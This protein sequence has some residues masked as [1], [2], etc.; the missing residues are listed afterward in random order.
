MEKNDCICID[1]QNCIIRDF[2]EFPMTNTE[3]NLEK[4]GEE[5]IGIF[6]AGCYSEHNKNNPDYETSY[7]DYFL[8]TEELFFN[9]IVCLNFKK[10]LPDCIKLWK[11][12]LEDD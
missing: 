9:T 11:R 6:I 5:H 7:Y 4:A 12:K 3:D 8:N 10:E 1:C 2:E